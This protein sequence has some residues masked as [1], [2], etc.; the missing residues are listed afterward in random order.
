[1]TQFTFYEI[2]KDVM[3]MLD[4]DATRGQFMKAICRFMFEEEPV[5]P[6]K[7]NKSEYF[8]ENII[9]VM[10]ESKEAEKNG[11]RPKRLNM[12][13]K[14]FTFQYAYYKAILLMTDEEIWQ[15]V[16]AIYDYMVDG[17]EPKD[18]NNNVTLYFNLA[19]RKLDIS[20]TRSIIGKHVGK[21]RKQTA[22]MTLDQFLTAN[23]HIRNNLYGNAVELVKDKDFSVLSDKLKASSKWA[24]EQSLYKILSH[25][26]EIISL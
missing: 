24:N 19:K 5:K 11:K 12:K 4:D 1:M 14:H 26:D 21:P 17:G 3:E 22:E 6:P 15:Y 7:G 18:L 2:Y 13:M 23:P 8:W 16:K 10:T 25:Y 9:N 20:K